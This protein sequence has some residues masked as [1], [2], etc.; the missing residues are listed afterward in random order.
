MMRHLARSTR[1]SCNASSHA[2]WFSTVSATKTKVRTAAQTSMHLKRHC[3]EW[4]CA[5]MPGT[6]R[7]VT[8]P[9]WMVPSAMEAACPRSIVRRTRSPACEMSADDGEQRTLKRLTP[10][11]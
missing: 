4:A 6:H 5:L 10:H 2:L 8:S 11:P 1:T 9:I 7:S 3:E